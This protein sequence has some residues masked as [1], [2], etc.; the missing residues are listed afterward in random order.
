MKL[1]QCIKPGLLSVAIASSFSTSAVEVSEQELATLKAQIAALQTRLAQLEEQAKP[2]SQ[3]ENQPSSSQNQSTESV[4]LAKQQKSVETNSVE[5]TD[6]EAEESTDGIKFGGAIRT[7]YS[8]T[9]YDDGNKNRGGDFDFDIFR[10]NMSGEV[11]GV[12]LN[13]EIRFFDYMTA[14]KYAYAGYQ[15]SENWQVQAG[16]TQVPF[17]N[18][19]YNSQNYFFSTNY[20][21]GLEDDF[22]LGV[23]FKRSV[24]DNWQLDV[25]FFKND[26]LGG[27]DGYV[28]NRSDRYSYDIVGIRTQGEG[29]Y[30]EPTEGLG[31][32]N[33]LAGRFAY[34]F[35]TGEV[36][37][38]VGVSALHGAIHNGE[39]RAGDYQAWA[40]HTSSQYQNWHLQFQHSQYDYDIGQADRLAV[41]AYSFYDSI[42]ADAKSTTLNIAYDMAVDFGPVTDLQFY[43]N[44]GLVYDKSDDSEDTMMNVLGMSVAAGGLFTY[45]DLVHAKNQPFIGG[46]AAGD[47]DETEQRFN[48]NIGYY[49]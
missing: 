6:A 41:G 19:A 37:T 36:K 28:D 40:F 24:A 5:T 15:F 21:L 16:I 4:D 45:F 17:G 38:E 26:E 29:I 10:I 11:G 30:D 25:G 14:V 31:E 43:N 46:S 47:T 18:Q 2:V 49:F 20:Y 35:N 22:D 7:N 9:S 33:T 42:A 23:V 39:K 44:F 27:V 12:T 3:S 8:Y 34:H 48:I 32:Y 1:T 13:S